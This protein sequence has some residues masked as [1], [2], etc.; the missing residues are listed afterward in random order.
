MSSCL[1]SSDRHCTLLMYN[2]LSI[3]TSTFRKY[4]NSDDIYKDLKS[5]R[6]DHYTSTSCQPRRFRQ[7]TYMYITLNKVIR[8]LILVH[9]ISEV[10]GVPIVPTHKQNYIPCKCDGVVWRYRVKLDLYGHKPIALS[11]VW[12]NYDTNIILYN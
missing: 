10:A 7:H 8:Q 5:I 6:I 11:F 2:S 4:Y 3:L 9:Y 12:T 1:K